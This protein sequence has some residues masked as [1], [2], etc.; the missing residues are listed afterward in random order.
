MNVT[1]PGQGE[2]H[3]YKGQ[4]IW[5]VDLRSACYSISLEIAQKDVYMRFIFLNEEESQDYFSLMHTNN[6]KTVHRNIRLQIR[7]QSTYSKNDTEK[8]QYP[9]LDE[10]DPSRHMTDKEIL[11]STIGWSEAYITEEQKQALLK[12]TEPSSF[13][14]EI[15][16]CPNMEL[17]LEL[18]DKTTFYIR[19]FPIKEE[20]NVIVD[21]EMRKGCLLRI[22]RK[23]LSSYSLP[24]ML[25]P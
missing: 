11:E 17:K 18:N 9:C 21:K 7:R 20:G 4:N 3:I 1:N 24:I 23:G 8:D 6:D 13:R 2:L 5:V 14:D 12:H 19:P 10:K 22:Y 15:G 25:K 16:L